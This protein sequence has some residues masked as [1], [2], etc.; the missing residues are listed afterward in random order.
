MRLLRHPVLDGHSRQLAFVSHPTR[1]R[2]S[3]A[4][5]PANRKRGT[6]PQ[7]PQG[8]SHCDERHGTDV[9]A[10]TPVEQERNRAVKRS[11]PKGEAQGE[12]HRDERQY[13]DVLA[14]PQRSTVSCMQR[15][16]RH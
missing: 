14:G 10:G 15:T 3:P 16:P 1:N 5:R 8:Q 2:P 12:S 9:V 11:D 13:I 7:P 6:F 4:S